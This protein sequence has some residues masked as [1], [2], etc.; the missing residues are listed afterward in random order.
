MAERVRQI[1]I[2]TPG[3]EFSQDEWRELNRV[4]GVQFSEEYQIEL[5]ECIREYIVEAVSYH[6]GATHGQVKKVLKDIKIASQRAANEL[7]RLS[8]D[9]AFF[10]DIKNSSNEK[11]DELMKELEFPSIDLEE[12][13]TDGAYSVVKMLMEHSFQKQFK[14]ELDFGSTIRFLKDIEGVCGSVEV[15]LTEFGVW[16]AHI[17]VLLWKISECYSRASGNG[18]Y[19]NG[20]YTFVHTVCTK[21]KEHLKRSSWGESNFFSKL[22]AV[23]ND[24]AENNRDTIKEKIKEG[25]KQTQIEA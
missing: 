9:L 8:D 12:K 6:E 4:A 13:E 17:N 19:S 18:P 15:D 23:T 20:S 5:L 16:D 25:Q 21:V 11:F 1:E 10:R 14:K 2:V 3:V 7:M 22:K 24:S